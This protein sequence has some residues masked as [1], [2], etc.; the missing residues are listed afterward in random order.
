MFREFLR[1]LPW[2]S[3]QARFKL[4]AC[5]GFRELVSIEQNASGRRGRDLAHTS[6]GVMSEGLSKS[7]V[8]G[9]G[10]DH[11]IRRL[12]AYPSPQ[13]VGFRILPVSDPRRREDQLRAHWIRLRNCDE[14]V[15]A[16]SCRFASHRSDVAQ[17][18]IALF[19]IETADVH[20]HRQLRGRSSY[21]DGLD[22]RA[23]SREADGNPAIFRERKGRCQDSQ[24]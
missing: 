22:Y 5:C 10:D 16:T 9:I 13:V 18:I 20:Y 12:H 3:G 11:Q 2:R 1:E 14:M 15:A 23:A 7:E 8:I 6:D 17:H 21:F 4:A 24:R 19:A